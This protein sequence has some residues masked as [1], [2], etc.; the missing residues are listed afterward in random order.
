[1]EVTEGDAGGAV[2][3]VEETGTV[4][5]ATGTAGE[6]DDVVVGVGREV[7]VDRSGADHRWIDTAD[8]E[9]CVLADPVVLVRGEVNKHVTPMVVAM[10]MKKM[11]RMEASS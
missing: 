10:R 8:V 1:V 6:G 9:G 2:V 3:V 7:A 4:V 5:V 11:R